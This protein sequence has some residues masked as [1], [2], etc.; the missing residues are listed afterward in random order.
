MRPTLKIIVAMIASI[1]AITCRA[2]ETVDFKNDL[3]PLFTKYG[4]NSGAC[5]G[6]AIGRAGF[7]LSLYGSNAEADYV[8]I[9]QQVNGRRVNLSKPDKS[10]L[11]LKPAEFVEHGGGSVFDIDSEA[12]KLLLRWIRSGVPSH[13][14]RKLASVE[15]SPKR[16]VTRSMDQPIPLK[17]IA[18]Y[19][20]GATR[21][22]TRWTIFKAED[23]SS[24]A[25]IDKDAA[26]QF[27]LP[28]RRGRHI[29]VA[30]F[31]SEV[32]PIEIVV[33]LSD[34]EANLADEVRENFIDTEVLKTLDELGLK[35]S[36]MID[37]ALYLRRVTLDLTGRLP[38]KEDAS[39]LVQTRSMN[40]EALI[41]KLSKSDGFTEYWTFQ[42]A[43][44][45]RL[46]P[47]IN[48]GQGAATYHRW[49]SKQI[50]DGVSYRNIA[51][52][53]ILATGDS[54]EHGPANF[55]RTVNGARP[56]AEFVSELFMG[57][58]LRCANCHNHPLDRWTQDDYHG[59][60]AIFATVE[61]GRVIKDKPSGIVIHPRTLVA[62][63]PRIPGEKFVQ[64]TQVRQTLADW[65][66]DASNP[67]FAKAIVNR[68]WKQMMGRGLVEPVDDFRAT[69]P[70][71]HPKLLNQL[72]DD[73]IANGYSLRH[74]L[75]V[76][77]SSTA[78]A[79][80]ANATAENKDDTRFYSHAMRRR[81]EPEVLA[82]AISDVM[83]IPAKYGDEPAGTRAVSLIDPKT[84]SRTLDVLGRC[85]RAESCESTTAA[86]GGLPQNLHLFNGPILNARIS[87][88]GGRLS[89]L[90]KARTSSADIIRDFYLAAFSRA[91][92]AEE[93][94]YWDKQLAASD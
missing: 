63:T 82:D 78:Y 10:L 34:S 46:R 68:L 80:S 66:T 49:L 17:T 60:A 52:Q 9:V 81:L 42:L 56:Q 16:R 24:V 39:S 57:S 71:T 47:Q 15:I 23:S 53:L 14:E 12:A 51:R 22:V 69:N 54:H 79:R 8:A 37:D 11:V 40:R 67:H 65:L 2:D 64:A 28:Q 88:K 26:G 83:G 90:I 94:Q 85:D 36:P 86:I 50:R 25:I 3:I 32:A 35:P 44:L 89:R 84:P 18:K 48:D 41:D 77:A 55:Y 62:A 72:A 38:L 76:I 29:V 74:T 73:F 21:D 61:S 70:A 13:S 19:A 30:R 7:K 75:K 45:L 43:K 59:L 31:L 6:S 20:D 91:P 1:F 27:A 87:M 93:K 5:H 92:N 33:P 4:C 58:R